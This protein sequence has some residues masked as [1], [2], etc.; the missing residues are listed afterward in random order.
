MD[1]CGLFTHILQGN[2]TGTG[3]IIWLPY[4]CPSASEV[5]LEDMGEIGPN[6]KPAQITTKLS[7]DLWTRWS[8]SSIFNPWHRIFM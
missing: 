5:T 6:T 4:D 1:L 2:F 3:A 8:V 7:M